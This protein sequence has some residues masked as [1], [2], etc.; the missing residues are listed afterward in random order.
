MLQCNKTDKKLEEVLVVS[1]CKGLKP[2][3]KNMSM[4][5]GKHFDGLYIYV[6]TMYHGLYMYVPTM[7]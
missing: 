4:T 1:V 7:Q 3:S 2:L 6:P 5:F